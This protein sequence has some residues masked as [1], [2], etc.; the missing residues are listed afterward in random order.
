MKQKQ[1]FPPQSQLEQPQGPVVT[2]NSTS[3][4]PYRWQNVVLLIVALLINLTT[5]GTVLGWP[6]IVVVLTELGVYSDLC[7]GTDCS[8]QTLRLSLIFIVGLSAN[9]V[10][11]LLLGLYLDRRNPKETALISQACCLLGCVGFGVAAYT[12]VDLWIPSFGLIGF[13]GYGFYLSIVGFSNL[14]PNNRALVVAAVVSSYSLSQLTGLAVL[15]AFEGGISLAA[16]YFAQA[17][18]IFIWMILILF[19]WPWRMYRPGARVVFRDNLPWQICRRDFKAAARAPSGRRPKLRDQIF[20]KP[21]QMAFWFYLIVFFCLAFYLATAHLQLALMGDAQTGYFYT[22]MFNIIGGLGFVSIPLFGVLA[23]RYGFEWTYFLAICFTIL[24]PFFALFNNLPLQYVTF[25]IWALC[26]QWTFSSNFAYIAAE[27][28]HQNYGLLVGIVTFGAGAFSNVQYGAL[29][30]VLNVL[31]GDFYWWNLG[32]AVGCF[33]LLLIPLFIGLRH[34]K[35]KRLA[36]L[37]KKEESN[38][39]PQNVNNAESS[40]ISI[41]MDEKS[42]L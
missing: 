10:A 39:N 37:E 23:D 26:R 17:V 13:G 33:F 24:F 30:F 2:V 1:S 9:Q 36:K 21:Y 34:Q 41:D 15:Y 11:G 19:L 5:S 31:N 35:Q 42:E 32:T 40:E 28:G 20:S 22:K 6:N 8:Q 4:K 25:S 29:A 18:L 12:K 38:E 27:F 7:K 16:I 3:D 14:F